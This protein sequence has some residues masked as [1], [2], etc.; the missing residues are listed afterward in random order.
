[1]GSFQRPVRVYDFT[2]FS[3]SRPS[4]QLPG[5]R[6]DAQFA[7][8]AD[9][10]QELQGALGR[11]VGVERLDPQVMA[12]L[13]AELVSRF[14]ARFEEFALAA[15]TAAEAARAAQDA[16]EAARVASLRA[17][18]EVAARLPLVEGAGKELKERVEE[19]LGELEAA[20]RDAAQGGDLEA[21]TPALY[22]GAGGP[23]ATDV[24]GATATSADYAQ[25]S[26]DWAEFMDGNATIPPNILAINAISG[27]HWSSRWWA[28][29]SAN[30]FGMLAWWYMGAWPGMPPSTPLSPTGQPIP[31][32]AMF[33]NTTTGT[34]M[35]WNGST[36]VNASAPQKGVTASLYYAATG[37]QTAF[38]LSVVDRHGNTFAFSATVPEGVEVFIDGAGRL[39]PQFDYTVSYPSSTVTLVAGAPAG[40]IVTID[41]LVPALALTPSGSANTLILNAIVPDGTTTVFSGLT[42]AATGALVSAA[43][44]EELFVSVDGVPQQ[45]GAAYTASGSSITFAEAPGAKANVYMVWYGP[46]VLAGSGGGG[47]PEAPN[48]GQ[49]YTRHSL[50]WAVGPGGL[51]DATVDGTLY[52]RKSGSWQHVTHNDLTDWAATIAPYALLAS[53]VFTGAPVAPTATAGTNTTQVATTAFVATAVAGVSGG[54]GG[55]AEAPNDGV[56]YARKSL[57]WSTLTHTDIADWGTAIGGYLP[58]TG[59]T[60]TGPLA[61]PA[62]NLNTSGTTLGSFYWDGADNSLH[63]LHSAS[64]GTVKLASDGSCS[65]SGVLSAAGGVLGGPL[66]VQGPA[67]LKVQNVTA[68]ASTSINRSLGENVSLTLGVAITALTITAWPASGVTGKVRLLISN[69]GGNSIAWPAG[70]KW[71]G[72]TAPT[73]SASGK[74]DIVLLMSD[75][76]G[77]TI[78]GSVV[79]Q[80]YR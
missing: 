49:Y 26:I 22:V 31:A 39:E 34:M 69:T 29:R 77:T 78:Y 16:A 3:R 80:D 37:G 41:V 38:P 19:R 59:G 33:F 21:Q 73:L 44:S 46:P 70:T 61:A 58:L 17:V 76:A 25:V 7:A 57:N 56:A 72:G 28:N 63:I 47:I 11:P 55:I 15:A 8:H 68:A 14:Q 1:M 64:G 75:N 48:D 40:A 50:A 23:Y 10:I 42:I 45:P 54:G 12:G 6:L 36:W 74:T 62:H 30:A 18:S 32:G 66:T 71:P 35:V 52:G 2:S 13:S 24:A 67:D 27:D 60:A 79:G 20:A 65:I 43:K 4:Q 5:D 53:P 9:A 51:T